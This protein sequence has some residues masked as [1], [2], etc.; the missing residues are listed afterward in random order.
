MNPIIPVITIDGPGGTG[1]GTISKM[2]AKRLGWHFLDSGILYR[3]LAMASQKH[4]IPFDAQEPLTQL[5]SHLDVRFSTSSQGSMTEIYLEGEEVSQVIRSEA[6]G[7][8]ASQVSQWPPVREALLQRQRAFRELPGLVTDGR[9]M[10]TVVFPDAPLKI[11]LAASPEER[12][13]RRQ[14]QLKEMG[15]DVTLSSLLEE[16]RVR[17]SRDQEREVSPLVA[18]ADAEVVDTTSL[19]IDEVFARVMREVGNRL[20]VG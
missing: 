15:I 10:G 6:C 12:A 11:F 2:L 19:T 3:A 16:L 18:A 14:Q 4:E 5:A 17:D 7:N 1:K 13:K 8:I 9:D 20:L